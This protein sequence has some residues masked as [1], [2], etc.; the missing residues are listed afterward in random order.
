MKFDNL[1]LSGGAWGIE[2]F[3]SIANVLVS[4]ISA[5]TCEQIKFLHKVFGTLY[6]KVQVNILHV[7]IH[8]R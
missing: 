7:V 2:R 4:K 1:P 6:A 3:S 5:A 8:H